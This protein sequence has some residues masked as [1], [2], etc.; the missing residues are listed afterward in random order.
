M[1]PNACVKF[2]MT[3]VGAKPCDIRE[4]GCALRDW[5]ARGGFPPERAQFP[6]VVARLGEFAYR[7]AFQVRKSSDIVALRAEFASVP[8]QA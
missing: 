8:V 4:H 2:I 7:A 3:S 5:L 1:D 6:G